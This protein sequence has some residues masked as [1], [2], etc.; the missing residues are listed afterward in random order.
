MGMRDHRAVDGAPRIDVEVGRLAI[1]AAFGDAEKI[2]HG[3]KVCSENTRAVSR[4]SREATSTFHRVA[5]PR[6]PEIKTCVDARRFP[7]LS[8]CA[9]SLKCSAAEALDIG[10]DTGRVPSETRDEGSGSG[11]SHLVAHSDRSRR[12]LPLKAFLDL[13][14]LVAEVG[15]ELETIFYRVAGVNHR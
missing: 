2:R 10:R 14:D 7:N 15:L 8:G 6:A 9:S 13:L 1:K 4:L 11:Y 5:W 3:K 12:G